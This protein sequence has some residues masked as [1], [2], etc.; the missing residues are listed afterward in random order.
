M[1][2]LIYG[3][4]EEKVM[5]TIARENGYERITTFYSDLSIAEWYG[6]NSIKESFRDITKSWISDYKFYTEFILCLNWKIWEWYHEEG[7]D[8]N[9]ILDHKNNEVA[10]VYNDLYY[11]AMEFFEKRYGEDDEV[12]Q[13]YFEVTD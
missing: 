3:A 1:D 13:Y 2:A 6:I 11:K 12:M 7:E 10:N 5:E 8:S 4:M 9:K